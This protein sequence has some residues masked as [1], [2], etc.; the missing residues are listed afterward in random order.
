MSKLLRAVVARTIKTR[1]RPVFLLIAP[2]GPMVNF[3]DIVDIVL[4][5]NVDGVVATN[6]TISREGLKTLTKRWSAWV[7]AG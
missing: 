3:D 1:H 5:E 6:T 4:E 7:P 2:D